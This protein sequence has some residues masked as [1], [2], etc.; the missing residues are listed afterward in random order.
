MAKTKKNDSNASSALS[1]FEKN[2][3]RRLH[4]THSIKSTTT[5]T[6]K[7]GAL[8]T[9]IWLWKSHWNTRVMLKIERTM[10]MGNAENSQ[11][12]YNGLTFLDNSRHFSVM[13]EKISVWLSFVKLFSVV[14]VVFQ[15]GWT[16]HC[17]FQCHILIVTETSYGDHCAQDTLEINSSINNNK[18]E[19]CFMHCPREFSLLVIAYLLL[20]PHIVLMYLTLLGSFSYS[21]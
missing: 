6:T 11:W 17:D 19:L 13:K 8:T 1:K 14:S 5:L 18:V 16:F 3:S 20:S 4:N 7:T 9:R 12:H 15:C 21:E 2:N 10:D